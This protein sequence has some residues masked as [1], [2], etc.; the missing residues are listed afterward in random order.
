MQPQFNE[1]VDWLRSL[2]AQYDAEVIGVTRSPSLSQP[3]GF[4]DSPFSSPFNS[5][6]S[7]ASASTDVGAAALPEA[8]MAWGAYRNDEADYGYGFGSISLDDSAFDEPVY[9]SM[10]S[11]MAGDAEFV[12]DPSYGMADEAPIARGFS[13]GSLDEGLDEAS[14]KKWLSAMPPLIRRQKAGQLGGSPF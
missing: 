7:H 6:R 14:E 8:P 1:H 12:D 2:R 10:G 5:P 3:V 11:I 4:G 13:F 9:R